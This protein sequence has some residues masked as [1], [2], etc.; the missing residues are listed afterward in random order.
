PAGRADD[1]SRVAPSGT[2][3]RS[4]GNP[5]AYR[6]TADDGSN[7]GRSAGPPEAAAAGRALPSVVGADPSWPPPVAHPA[8]AS[9]SPT[10][11]ASAGPMAAAS[12]SGRRA[13]T[14]RTTVLGTTDTVAGEAPVR[15]A[16]RTELHHRCGR[17]PH[18]RP[19]RAGR[20]RGR[21]DRGHEPRP[22]H[23]TRPRP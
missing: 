14:R 13:E 6:A 4:G 2:G 7:V 17:R 3:K 5:S 23:R 21:W 22:R 11:A 16:H 12:A 1:A 9:T 19:D 15:T 8:A 18:D 20:L 10:A